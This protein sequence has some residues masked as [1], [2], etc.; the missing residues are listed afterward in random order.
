[1]RPNMSPVRPLTADALCRRCDPAQ[2]SFSTTAEIEP[3]ED[4]IGQQRAESALRFGLGIR[5]DGFNLFAMG[6]A[7][8]GKHTL[9]RAFLERNAAQ[10]TVPDDIC[11]V[12]NF[13]RSHE[14]RALRL[15]QGTGRMLREDVKHLV[16]DLRT[17]LPAA[18]ETDEFRKGKEEIESDLKS[19]HKAKLQALEE[20]ATASNIAIVRTP[21]GLA[22]APVHLGEIIPPDEF[23]KLPEEKRKEYLASMEELQGELRDALEAVPRLEKEARE[24]VR[25]LVREVAAT[26]TGHLIEE[27]T[28]KYAAFPEVVTHLHA[29]ENDVL[30][31][32]EELLKAEEPGKEDGAGE[33]GELGLLR[34]SAR[35]R[36]YQVNLL[37]DHSETHG[38][39][40]VYE[41]HP[42]FQK[43]VGRI[44]HISQLGTLVTDLNLIKAGALHR[45]NGGYLMIDAKNL[46]R[47]PYAWEA[48][49]RALLA[50]QARIESLGQML[51]IVS[52]VSLE[53]EPISLDLK[54]VLLGDRELYGLLAQLDPDFLGLFKVAVDF[55]DDIDRTPETSIAYARMITAFVVK[56]GM[57]HFEAGAVARV[58][59]QVARSAADSE[60]LSAHMGELR[61]LV[62]ESEYWAGERGAVTVAAEDVDR[63]IRAQDERSGRIRERVLEEIERG[64]YLID[65]KGSR[66][67][68]INGLAVH[69][70]GRTA[71]GRPSRITAKVRLGKGQLVDIEREAELSGP[72]HSKGVFILAGFLGARYAP[73]HP[74]SLDAS[75]VFE[76]S[77]GVV[78]G[79]SASCAEL[80]ALLSALADVPLKQSLAMTGSVNQHG[81]IQAIGGV[82]E[83]IEGFFDVCSKRGMSGQE[84]VVI[85]ASN[86]KHL[87]LRRDVVLAV[88]KGL[89]SI[90]PMETVDQALE[91]LSDVPA[92][93]RDAAGKFPEGSVNH[94]VEA[95]LIA[96]AER[97]LALADGGAPKT[98]AEKAAEKEISAEA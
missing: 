57:R 31:N 94:R 38:A 22:L 36:K 49:K 44:E 30:T 35:F 95:R 18:F 51:N 81:Q 33:V 46:L 8:A 93:E 63:A 70:S 37:V 24:R 6:P 78:E 83:K 27:L 68:Q 2:L 42:T 58:L 64:T 69:M 48:L 26:R 54:V 4:A 40:V 21:A 5:K 16:E 23:E 87:M 9:V 11:Y 34:P 29:L 50:K 61:D 28:K 97:R 88:E 19:R 56:E 60:K 74:L 91:L 15:P 7:G 39:P 17:A 1:M 85:P 47:E 62:R 77:Y 89:F 25:K 72:I 45:A 71:F 65:T 32:V 92:G 3:L 96:F 12:H 84:G 20:R 13:E 67:G 98:S 43:L 79:D 80:C 10:R 90:F 75:I 59:D 14:P 73:D 53:P 76:Q 66:V 82:N 41:N 86:V 55:E 52:T